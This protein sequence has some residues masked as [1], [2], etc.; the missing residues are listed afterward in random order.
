[1]VEICERH[2]V[3]VLTA[4]GST[5]RA[6]EIPGDLDRAV[7]FTESSDMLALQEDLVQMSPTD[8]SI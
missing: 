4:F 6:R 2:G 7:A 8:A 1:M 5:V 3:R